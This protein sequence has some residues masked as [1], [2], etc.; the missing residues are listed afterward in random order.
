MANVETV[1]SKQLQAKLKEILED[2]PLYR[3]YNGTAAEYLP[4]EISFFCD[5]SQCQKIQLWKKGAHSYAYKR[6]WGTESYT[7]K[8]CTSNVINFYY[9]WSGLG[10]DNSGT[11]L[12]AG[13]FPPLRKEPPERLAKKLNKVDHDLYR[14][15]LTSRNNSY[16]LGALAYLRRVV[17][18]RMND[19][20]D[21]LHEGAKQDNTAGAELQ[22]IEEV[23][24]NWV[25][26]NKISYASNLLPKRLKPGGVNP[27]DML[28]DL[29]SDGIHHRTEDECLAIFDRCKTAFEYVFGELDVQIEDAKA[30]IASLAP[31]K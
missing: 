31:S 18:N 14:K 10:Q 5:D 7:C 3:E 6:G 24:K 22:K 28:H 2:W 9:F 20:L 17:E 23:K 21:L 12:K 13:Q 11:F 26:D 4:D 1:S 15:A 30:Y 29:A 25:F 27:I 19:L 16:G 8:N